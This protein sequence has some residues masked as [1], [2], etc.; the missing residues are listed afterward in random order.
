MKKLI[1]TELIFIFLATTFIVDSPTPG[2]YQQ[3]LP[4]NKTINDIFFIDSLTGWIV[5]SN[6]HYPAND[7][8]YIL[9]TI[10]GGTNWSV[11]LD[12]MFNYYSVKF[13]NANTGYVGGGT[14]R[15]KFL[16]TTDGGNSWSVSTPFGSNMYAI[17][18]ISFV[19]NDT[20][21]IC[22]DDSFG[23][24]IFKTTN[25][26]VSWQ[27]QLGASY[28]I[29]KLFFLN[30]DT[31]W[32]ISN[33]ASGKLYRT[34]NSGVIWNLQYPFSS[35]L[36]S[37]FFTSKDTGFIGG[38]F[39]SYFVTKTTNGGFNWV[40]T[41]NSQ[42]GRGLYF[43]NNSIGWLCDV[44]SIVQKTTDG[45]VNWFGQTSPSGFYYNIQFTDTSKGWSAG[46]ILIHT[47]DGGGPAGIHKIGNEI[48]SKYK[49][50]QNYPNPFNPTTKI[51]FN[52]PLSRG[53][54]EGWGVLTRLTIYDI[55]GREVATLVNEQLKPGNYEVE[56][57][58]S[59]YASGVY[60]YKLQT[61]EFIETK[62]MILL[63]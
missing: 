1:L 28:L 43:I 11:K 14:G 45:G 29:K 61:N 31:G 30:K 13:L 17:L 33:E 41:T 24:G 59:S 42:G 15:A 8:G 23:G 7:T 37:I 49:L 20:G 19:N 50:Y 25:G 21:W 16:K 44:F 12:S 22:S 32:A 55:L 36:S 62:K 48:P 60:F 58:G 5:S 53:V 3:T 6:T 52:I 57:N 63:K 27:Q 2:W 35:G 56:W 38:G 9:K 46:T 39:G 54:P 18:D 26:G 47:S 10:N 34:T 4:V 51:K 40:P